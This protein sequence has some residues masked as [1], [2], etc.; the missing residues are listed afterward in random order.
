MCR[1]SA[2][3][4]TQTPTIRCSRPNSEPA[5]DDEQGAGQQA[6]A[7]VQGKDGAA[8]AAFFRQQHEP[9]CPQELGS[10]EHEQQP[11]QSAADGSITD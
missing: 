10:E 4:S 1:A 3:S 8:Y 6:E 2:I 5:A 11:V 9:Q 7:F